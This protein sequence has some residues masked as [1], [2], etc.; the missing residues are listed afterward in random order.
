MMKSRWNF[1][2]NYDVI[3]SQLIL[4]EYSPVQPK[5][6]SLSTSVRDA[7]WKYNVE[8]VGTRALETWRLDTRGGEHPGSRPAGA[9]DQTPEATR[10]DAKEAAEEQGNLS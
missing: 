8:A 1:G 5:H 6:L 2:A 3:Q 9:L 4:T 7:A 10:T